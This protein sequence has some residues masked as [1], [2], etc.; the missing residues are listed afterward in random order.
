MRRHASVPC[1]SPLL[2]STRD[3]RSLSSSRLKLLHW[4]KKIKKQNKI[5]ISVAP[6]PPNPP[7]PRG[8]CSYV[9]FLSRCIL[10]GSQSNPA[11][12]FGAWSS[13][14]WDLNVW[15]GRH[16]RH[17]HPL[18]GG[19]TC[20][21]TRSIDQLS[22]LKGIKCS[23]L[24]L[25]L[26]VKL[27]ILWLKKTNKTIYGEM[28]LYDKDED[29]YIL[30]ILKKNKKKTI[31][32]AMMNGLLLFCSVHRSMLHRSV[33]LMFFILRSQQAD[34][35]TLTPLFLWQHIC[36]RITSWSYFWRFNTSSVNDY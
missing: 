7:T 6:L 29:F 18:R 13:C 2:S 23:I 3:G 24:I 19:E 17:R 21:A 26:V 8:L 15:R 20:V 10:N 25:V 4:K 9:L 27:S 1:R 28:L 36:C 16:R 33:S 32:V 12:R 5:W 30:Q 22:Y 34:S 31:S 11:V 35:K 14:S